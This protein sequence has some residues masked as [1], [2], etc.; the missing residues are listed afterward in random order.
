MSWLY[1]NNHLSLFLIHAPLAILKD[2]PQDFLNKLN[3]SP[4][5]LKAG[6]TYMEIL[7]KKN[8][9]IHSGQC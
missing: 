2:F 3:V 9:N 7:S 8:H 4:A 1:F 6:I 5:T